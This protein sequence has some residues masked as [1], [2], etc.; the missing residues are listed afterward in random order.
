MT[1]AEST[2]HSTIGTRLASLIP[3]L[4]CPSCSGAVDV[5]ERELVCAQC[6]RRYAVVGEM[7]VLLDEESTA[8]IEAARDGAENVRLRSTLRQSGILRLIDA[9]RPPHPFLFLNGRLNRGAFSALVSSTGVETVVL[10][11]GSGLLKG[12]NASGLSEHVYNSLIPLEIAAGPGIGVV[13]DAHKLPFGDNS[14]DGVLI[15]GV[16][17]HVRD[18]ERI[19]GEIWRVLKPGAPVYVD[20]PFVQHY[21]LDPFDFR[22]YTVYGIEHLF[23][24][25]ERVDSGVAAGP[26]SAL[27]DMLTE[28]PALLFRSP[29]MYWGVKFV[30]GWLTSPI[31][32][33][34]VFW[35][36]AP[37]AHIASGAVYYL[38]RKP[39]T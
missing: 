3:R 6:R 24:R 4:A 5:D 20:V 36:K 37:R 38:G 34:D 19:A 35:S 28:F 27:A 29:M 12:L 25:F 10:D 15:Q 26:A 30:T 9:V 33:L 11:I 14:L 1:R 21:H 7:A 23:G 8:E 39:A 18:P 31:R 22:R 17:E 2:P 32:F 16:L 13:G